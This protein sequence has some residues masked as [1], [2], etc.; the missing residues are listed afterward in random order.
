MPKITFLNLNVEKRDKIKKAIIN[1]FSRHTIAKASISNIVEEAQIPRGSFYQYFEDK[2][3]ALKYIIDESIKIE[4]EEIKNS[5]KRNNGDIFATSIDIFKYVSKRS[6]NDTDMMLCHNIIQKLKEE[7]VNI[8]DGINSRSMC[9]AKKENGNIIDTDMLK[10]NNEEDLKYIMKILTVVIR[11]SI[12]D[13]ITKKKSEEEAQKELEKQLE[14][15]KYG[16]IK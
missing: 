6:Y 15:L 14:I 16:M 13:V 11:A 7:N 12:I 10:L 4:K 8:F 3:D 1:E 2:E 5:L 9:Q